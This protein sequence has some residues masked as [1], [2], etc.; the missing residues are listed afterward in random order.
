MKCD[1]FKSVGGDR[2]I[3]Q[4]KRVD[5]QNLSDPGSSEESGCKERRKEGGKETTKL[6]IHSLFVPSATFNQ[7][8]QLNTLLYIYGGNQ[9]CRWQLQRA[10]KWVMDVKFNQLNEPGGILQPHKLCVFIQMSLLD[11]W[12]KM[13]LGDNKG[14]LLHKVYSKTAAPLWQVPSNQNDCN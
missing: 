9:F 10:D 2:V 5:H 11:N 6:Y 7:P 12:R 13:C 14:W 3:M 4:T 1:L 8:K